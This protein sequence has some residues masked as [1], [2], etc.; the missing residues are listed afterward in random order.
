MP[1][2]QAQPAVQ[3]VEPAAVT[4]AR[5]FDALFRRALGGNPR[6]AELLRAEG[7][8]PEHP[9]PTYP[10]SVWKACVEVARK[11]LFGSLPVTDGHRALG[12]L[13]SD[14][15]VATPIGQAFEGVAYTGVAYLVRLPGMMQRVRPDLAVELTFEAERR[16]TLAVR[17]PNSNAH[18][19][20]GLVEARV[21]QRGLPAEVEVARVDAQGYDLRITW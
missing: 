15:F 2:S 19:M 14:G 12:R 10:T 17:G 8:D 11:E 5:A 1:A 3:A 18:F 4:H 7:Y 16:C 6:L 21:V 13:F 20:A 9:R